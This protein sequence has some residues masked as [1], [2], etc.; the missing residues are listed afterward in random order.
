MRA[1]RPPN[2]H[3]RRHRSAAAPP[4]THPKHRR[5][6]EQNAARLWQGY[7]VL[8]EARIG[9]GSSLSSLFLGDGGVCMPSLSLVQREQAGDQRPEPAAAPPR[10]LP[11]QHAT[12]ATSAHRPVVLQQRPRAATA[13]SVAAAAG[14]VAA[15]RAALAPR[16]HRAELAPVGIGAGDGQRVGHDRRRRRL[17]RIIVAAGR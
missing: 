17:L 16:E 3:R 13:A 7:R 10:L 5:V 11:T 4:V 8:R 15:P 9:V 6:G 2:H 14:G 12:P 1:S